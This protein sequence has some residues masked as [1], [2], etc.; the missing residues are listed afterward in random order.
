MD[1]RG[2]H[3]DLRGS[4]HRSVIPYVHRRMG[5]ILQCVVQALAWSFF[6]LTFAWPFT[7][8][9]HGKYNMT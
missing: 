2:G 5:V 1:E 3:Q 6:I 7:A 4:D 8:Q 9:D